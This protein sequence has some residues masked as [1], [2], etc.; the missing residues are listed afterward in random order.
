MI[1]FFHLWFAV[2]IIFKEKK[3]QFRADWKA[4]KCKK[5]EAERNVNIII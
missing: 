1:I 2:K 5:A 3:K 4:T